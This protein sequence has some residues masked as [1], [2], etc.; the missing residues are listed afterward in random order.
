MVPVSISRYMYFKCLKS[1]SRSLPRSVRISLVEKALLV[2]A[3]NTTLVKLL[4]NQINVNQ[5]LLY[6]TV[7]SCSVQ[8]Q[9]FC[10]ILHRHHC[11][12]PGFHWWLL[13]MRHHVQGAAASAP[14]SEPWDSN[15]GTMYHTVR[16]VGLWSRHH[17]V[18]RKYRRHWSDKGTSIYI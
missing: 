9:C 8:R 17:N 16:S 4:H 18:R 13:R 15:R 2:Y 5:V 1:I 14:R 6:R 11:L 3:K 7:R 10:G 12:H